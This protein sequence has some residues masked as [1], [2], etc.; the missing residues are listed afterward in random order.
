MSGAPASP[1]TAGGGPRRSVQA[2]RSR[3]QPATAAAVRRI[4]VMRRK[5]RRP[6]ARDR[7]ERLSVPESNRGIMGAP[8][9]HCKG[10]RRSADGRDTARKSRSAPDP[11]GHIRATGLDSATMEMD[12]P[13]NPI[14]L[15]ERIAASDARR[16]AIMG[17]TPG[18]GKA[19]T[20]GNLLRGLQDRGQEVGIVAAGREEEDVEFTQPPRGLSLPLRMGTVVATS[21]AALERSTATVETIEKTGIETHQ[22]P[23]VIALVLADGEVEPLGPA[24]AHELREIVDSVARHTGGRVL[25]EGSFNRRSFAAPGIADGIILSIGAALAPELERTVAGS[26]YYVEIFNLEACEHRVADVF[27]VAESEDAAVLLNDENAIVGGIPWRALGNAKLLLSQTHPPFQRIVI[28]RS[29]GDEFVIPLLREKMQFEI[30]VRDPMRIALSPVY[31]S[32]WQKLGGGIRVVHATRV[33]ALSLNPTNPAG[34][35]QDPEEFLEAFRERI[36]EIPSHDV[37]LEQ[38]PVQPRKRWFGIGASSD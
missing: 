17:L 8:S 27:P 6:R 21:A 28:P 9:S 29:V 14:T 10:A 37:V 3:E 23:I 36:P 7:R 38:T 2:A 22:G 15:V 33:L 25:I 32:A 20:L 30:V 35:D 16:V 18:A 19:T 12:S 34:P 5:P 11:C 4:P 31:Y 26:R 1:G 24:S 13:D